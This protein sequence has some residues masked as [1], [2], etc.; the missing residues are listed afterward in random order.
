MS[1][2]VAYN[3]WKELLRDGFRTVRYLSDYISVKN[4]ILSIIA[5]VFFITHN[6]VRQY[7]EELESLRS[8]CS[9]WFTEVTESG[10]IRQIY[11]NISHL[12]QMMCRISQ[13]WLSLIES[14]I[15]L[16]LIQ[17]QHTRHEEDNQY[18]VHN[19]VYTG[20]HLG[21]GVICPHPQDMTDSLM[22]YYDDFGRQVETRIGSLTRVSGDQN[23]WKLR[24]SPSDGM[25]NSQNWNRPIFKE[26][27]WAI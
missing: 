17:R 16:V 27:P 2:L 5:D 22:C 19:Y 7:L 9:H 20:L 25:L 1:E 24:R 10:R 15:N 23:F 12:M 3:S 14:Y 11:S 6:T 26:R 8:E 21:G 4:T 13:K 18:S